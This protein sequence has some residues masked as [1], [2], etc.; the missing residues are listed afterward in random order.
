[1]TLLIPIPPY[2]WCPT[3]KKPRRIV[4]AVAPRIRHL[5]LLLGPLLRSWGC[6][7]FLCG[8]RPCYVTYYEGR[9]IGVAQIGP[10]FVNGRDEGTA[11]SPAATG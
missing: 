8:S 3:A 7:P 1:M 10:G 9:M 2:L 6:D 5:I 4:A 11:T